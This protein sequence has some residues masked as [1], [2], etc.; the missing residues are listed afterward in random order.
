MVEKEM[1]LKLPAGSKGLNFNY[2]APIDPAF[3][4]KIKIPSD[5]KD[6]MAK[7]L[8][9]LPN[10]PVKTSGGLSERISWWTPTLG[11]VLEDREFLNDRNGRYKRRLLPR[12]MASGSFISTGIRERG[13][14]QCVDDSPS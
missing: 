1:G 6:S 9:T 2:K 10:K 4:A 3:L 12:R 7:Q 11:N 13:T 14:E 5:A 8:S